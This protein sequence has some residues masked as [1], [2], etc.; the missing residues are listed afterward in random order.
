MTASNG[1]A[2]GELALSMSGGGARAAY[3]VGLLRHVAKLFPELRVPI[4]TGV[5]AGAI[6]TA[7]LANDPRP[8]AARVSGLADLW[9]SLTTEQVFESHALPLLLTASRWALRL[10]SGGSKLAPPTRG[11]VDT[12]PLRRFLE[13]ALG[14]EEGVLRG[15][16]RNLEAG[17][18]RAVGLTTTDYA[19]GQTITHVQ[20]KDIRTWERPN[21]RSVLAELGVAHVM[22]SSALPLFFPAVRIGDT[23]HGDGGMRLTAPLAPALHLGAQRILVISTRYG[24]SQREA[25]QPATVG[26]PPPAQVIGLLLN[27]IFLDMVDQ[28]AL[29]MSRINDLLRLVPEEQRGDLRVVELLVLRPSVD[30]AKLASSYEPRLPQPFRFLTRGLGTRETR[31]PDSLSMVMFEPEYLR[32]LMEIGERDAEARSA[33]LRAFVGGEDLPSVQ[34][35][36]FWKI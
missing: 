18:L 24:R 20:G 11:M 12:A 27:A 36:G 34:R 35:T 23:W 31:S 19:T 6:N 29:R 3:Q 13:A 17:R 7:Y 14:T 25:D 30:L 15:I 8:F 1:A 26:Y 10:V 21:R 32:L 28:D 4:M 33:E 9:A 16:P 5:S 2:A 22:A